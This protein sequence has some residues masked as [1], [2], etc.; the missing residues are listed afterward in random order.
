MLRY[1]RV[2]E[3]WNEG[4]LV[5]YVKMKTS[6]FHSAEGLL[7]QLQGQCHRRRQKRAVGS[8]IPLCN[9]S[10]PFLI[11]FSFFNIRFF[12]LCSKRPNFFNSYSNQLLEPFWLL[13]PI[14]CTS[15]FFKLF[16]Q[17]ER[18]PLKPCIFFFTFFLSQ[19][20]FCP[21]LL[22]KQNSGAANEQKILSSGL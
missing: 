7:I 2:T 15:G 19:F 5:T 4:D 9:W 1:H 8:N 11:V 13:Y 22:R 10:W 20:Q 6:Y 16:L 3:L 18:L 21:P 14:E 17:L 12:I